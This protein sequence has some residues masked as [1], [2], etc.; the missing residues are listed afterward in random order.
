MHVLEAARKKPV[1]IPRDH[2]VTEAAD[3]MDRSAVGALVVTEADGRVVG[4]VTDRDLVVRGLARRVSADA[5]VDSVMSTDVVTLPADADLREALKVFEE[6]PIRRLPLVDGGKL[7]GMVTMDDL[8]IDLV[9]D[10]TRLT[11]PVVGQVLFGHR[12]PIAPATT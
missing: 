12:E 8:M 4:I 9:A 11:R 7:A 6:Q 2:T 1:T 3:L 5:R 10:L